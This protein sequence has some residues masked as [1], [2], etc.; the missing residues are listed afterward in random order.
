MKE[1]LEA[2]AK[3]TAAIGKVAKA[4]LNKFDNY[5]FASIDNFL[6]AVN[7]PLAECGLVVV[8]QEL[9]VAKTT[10]K[11][12]KP[13]LS[14]EFGFTLHH[15]SGESL[16]EIRRHVAVPWTGSQ[17]YGSAQ[18]YALKQYLRAQFLVA[19]GDKDDPDH[20]A[21][22]AGAP[23]VGVVSYPISTEQ[24]D[25]LEAMGSAEPFGDY[26]VFREFVRL[27]FN[28]AP[29]QLTADQA[30]KLIRFVAAQPD[31]DQWPEKQK[32]ALRLSKQ[33]AAQSEEEQLEV[34]T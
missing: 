4:D 21:S 28:V 30:D 29:A 34:A 9:S 31:P 5:Q 17:S 7:G 25:K 15:I 3:A 1:I 19:T 24:V 2:V 16:P 33:T 6:A 32:V 11:N 12:D 22:D 14:F 26:A 10:G 13:W 27:G 8:T 18:S 23:P 20:G